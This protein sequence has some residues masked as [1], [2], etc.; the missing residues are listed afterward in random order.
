MQDPQNADVIRLDPVEDDVPA[1]EPAADVCPKITAY[2]SPVRM[3]GEI[4][5]HLVK[6]AQ[7]NR[8]RS[9]SPALPALPIDV[10]K[11]GFGLDC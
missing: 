11:V 9:L 5:K 1:G 2:P 6:I 7:I 10:A 8:R 3:V 4:M